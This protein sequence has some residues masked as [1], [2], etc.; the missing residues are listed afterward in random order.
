M[1][2]KLMT[3]LSGEQIT[4]VTDWEKIR[5]E[6]LRYLLE[7]YAY[8]HRPVEKPDKV[9]FTVAEEK[10]LSGLQFKKVLIDADGFVLPIRV[11]IPKMDKPVPC[12]VYFMHNSQQISTD[13]E[14]EPNNLYVPIAEI[15]KRGYAVAVIYFND[16]YPDHKNLRTYDC[17]IFSHF[18]PF[19]DKRQDSD[20]AAIAAWAWGASRAADYLVTDPQIDPE[21]LAVAG[22]SRGGKAA[23]W[24]G[25]T[26]E[27][28][29]LTI[30]N[31]SG[32]MG[33]AMLRGKTG[34][35]IDFISTHTDWLCRKQWSYA[36]CEEMFPVDQHM[37]LALIAP[38]LLY[39]QS[40]ILD[41]WSDPS[42]ERRSC[43]LAG[44]AYALYGKDGLIISEEIE[45]DF[46]YHEG[47]IGYHVSTGE[48]K[49]R[50]NDW[51]MF[52]NFWDKHRK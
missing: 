45:S 10:E 35:H 11:F 48:H 13:I 9:T 40:S 46:G 22:H 29:R 7:H 28:F 26:D 51:E 2:P 24:T 52:M 14:N 37:L 8:G 4:N 50:A 5:R 49:I 31:S 25:A 19:G 21:N 33:A 27:R 23:L 15:G 36:D 34:E 47:N 12:F 17:G 32:C 1:E 38:R 3:S 16:I 20:W 42:A 39:V 44:E 30:S 43:K 6:E 41:D 18:G